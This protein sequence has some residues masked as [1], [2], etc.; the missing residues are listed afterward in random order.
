MFVYRAFELPGC[1]SPAVPM[2]ATCFAMGAASVMRARRYAAVDGMKKSLAILSGPL[3]EKAETVSKML[4][5]APGLGTSHLVTR[6]APLAAAL[7]VL[8]IAN[9][10]G[11]ID[12][13]DRTGFVWAIR[14]AAFCLLWTV[15]H[16]CHDLVLRWLAFRALLVAA[17]AKLTDPELELFSVKKCPEP[18][19]FRRAAGQI[20]NV[21]FTLALCFVALVVFFSTYSPQAPNALGRWLL[22][23]FLVVGAIV[24][25][26][27]VGLEKD[28]VLSKINDSP[29]GELTAEFWLRLAVFGALPLL[30]LVGHLFPELSGF[31]SN[32]V[33][34]GVE[35]LR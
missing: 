1:V 23:L 12:P 17:R 6:P 16:Y 10:D 2:L 24:T 9:M 26:V 28:Y 4:M 34:P 11:A 29:P 32:W 7:V 20:H 33:Q 18:S 13:F 35:A 30:G 14:V 3:Q 15:F 8:L 27:L 21:A 5:R 19:Y 25:T 31:V 22:V